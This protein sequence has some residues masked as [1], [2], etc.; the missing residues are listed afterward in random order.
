MDSVIA[1]VKAGRPPNPMARKVARERA[2]AQRYG[3]RPAEVHEVLEG[4][5]FAGEVFLLG[6]HIDLQTRLA[7]NKRLDLRQRCGGLKPGAQRLNS[8]APVEQ[9]LDD[10]KVSPQFA[11]EHGSGNLED[12]DHLPGA[13]A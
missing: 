10:R 11:V 4:L 12:A 8:W 2:E 6:L 5:S 1:P 9:A 7:F 13:A 3:K